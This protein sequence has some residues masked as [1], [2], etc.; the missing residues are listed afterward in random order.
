[1]FQHAYAFAQ[2][3]GKRNTVGISS[4]ADRFRFWKAVRISAGKV[5]KLFKLKHKRT[6]FLSSKDRCMD[7]DDNA[8]DATDH[9]DDVA[10]YLA[11]R[12]S[13]HVPSTCH[14]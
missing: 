12:C 9:A 11:V 7:A 8:D 13:V 5:K 14:A 6:V 2:R 1:M 4:H 3:I 10:E